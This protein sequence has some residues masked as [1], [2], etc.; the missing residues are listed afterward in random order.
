MRLLFHFLLSGGSGGLPPLLKLFYT[1]SLQTSRKV[2][3]FFRRGM[4]MLGKI[5]LAAPIPS[6]EV[7]AGGQVV[8]GGQTD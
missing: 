5:L 2:D 4:L 8:A 1:F 7:R 6:D 3:L